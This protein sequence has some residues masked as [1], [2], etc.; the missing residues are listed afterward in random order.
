MIIHIRYWLA[1]FMF[2]L[3]FILMPKGPA[4]TLLFIKFREFGNIVV[5]GVFDFQFR[6]MIKEDPVLSAKVGGL[7]DEEFD[8]LKEKFKEAISKG[9]GNPLDV[10]SEGVDPQADGET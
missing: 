5:E 7:T 1:D 2:T 9:D 6:A 10:F 4:R 3:G 8:E